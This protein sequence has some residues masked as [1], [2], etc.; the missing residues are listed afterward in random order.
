MARK[1]P[2]GL[3]GY[4]ASISMQDGSQ[5]KCKLVKWLLSDLKVC[6]NCSLAPSKLYNLQCS[7]KLCQ[8]CFN[9][10]ACYFCPMDNT[11]SQQYETTPFWTF[12]SGLLKTKVECP[13]CDTVYKFSKFEEHLKTR[14]PEI[15]PMMQPSMPESKQAMEPNAIRP[16]PGFPGHVSPIGRISTHIRQLF[17]LCK[18]MMRSTQ[19]NFLSSN[20]F[21]NYD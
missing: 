11:R 18:K 6:I 3:E 13:I 4:F 2:D 7:H 19:I 16:P 12:N 1:Q 14:H 17:G 15:A 10:H 20:F 8:A 9:K 5:M 21:L